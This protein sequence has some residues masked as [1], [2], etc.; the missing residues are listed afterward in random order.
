LQDFQKH[1]S[2]EVIDHSSLSY[3][4]E[5]LIKLEEKRIDAQTTQT[6]QKEGKTKDAYLQSIG[7]INE[8]IYQDGLRK[9]AERDLTLVFAIQKI[10]TELKI[11]VSESDVNAYFEKLGKLYGMNVDDIK[12]KYKNN[13]GGVEAFIY[14]NKIYQELLE[15]YK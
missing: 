3:F 1:F 15:F 11:E 12:K 5:S 2:E 4:P 14:Q 7:Y 8:K 6:A 10:G 13:L 9:T